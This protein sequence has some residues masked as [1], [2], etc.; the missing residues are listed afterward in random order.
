M[1]QEYSELQLSD[2]DVM[3]ACT[4]VSRFMV[5]KKKDLIFRI[6]QS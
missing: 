1:I 5:D 2:L 6:L 4:T 3:K